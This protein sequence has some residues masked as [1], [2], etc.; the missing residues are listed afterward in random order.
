MAKVDA[1]LRC[2]AILFDMDGTLVDSSA[3]VRQAWTW[4]T[5]R[6]GVPLEPLL[7]V[8]KGRPNIE[9]LRQ[10]APKH[11][12]IEAEAA[13]LLDFESTETDGLAAV[14]GAREAVAAAEKGPWGVVTSANQ[15]LAEVRLRAVGISVPDVLIGVDSIVHGKPHP[16]CFLQAAERLGVDPADCLVFEDA[17]AGI[18]AAHAAG[19]KVVGVLT[20]LTHHALNADAHIRDFRDAAILRHNRNFHVTLRAAAELSFCI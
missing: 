14:A 9:V 1:D 4:W 13:L 5:S 17:P 6:H 12:N 2:S 19:M 20:S 10:F 16:E 15:S 18:A 7:A 8:E 3:V 11:V